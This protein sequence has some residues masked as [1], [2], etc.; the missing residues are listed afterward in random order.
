M[1]RR[2]GKLVGLT[3]ALLKGDKDTHVVFTRED[4]DRGTCELGG[5]LVEASGSDTLFRAGDVESAHRRVMRC[6]FGEIRNT[7]ELLVR[8]GAMLRHRKREV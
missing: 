3:I 8:R 6:L 1:R 4:L 7:D 2:V 5:D